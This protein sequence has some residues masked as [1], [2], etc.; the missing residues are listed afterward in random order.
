[1]STPRM[2]TTSREA[3]EVPKHGARSVLPTT[4]EKSD[5]NPQAECR[6]GEGQASTRP[7]SE[8]EAHK[9]HHSDP[10]KPTPSRTEA[11]KKPGAQSK[12]H[13]EQRKP[14]GPSAAHIQPSDTRRR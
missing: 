10:S 12:T 8:S 6:P 11:S 7:K 4:H 9:S 5:K 2:S 3:T 1:M 14:P 13:R